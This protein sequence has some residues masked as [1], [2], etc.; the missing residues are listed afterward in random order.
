MDCRPVALLALLLVLAGCDA[1]EHPVAADSSFE[2]TVTGAQSITLTGR[3]G[4]AYQERGI[5]TLWLMLTNDDPSSGGLSF[6]RSYDLTLRPGT[7][8]VGPGEALA[9][10]FH[11]YLTLPT[12]PDS[13]TTYWAFDGTLTVDTIT[14]GIAQGS[15][16][17]QAGPGPGIADPVAVAE[18][19][20]KAIVNERD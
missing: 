11:A 19:T 1:A 5:P 15:F 10:G 13:V 4:T 16:S 18:G 12:A 2:A 8:N 6:S 9:G 14:D 3:T 7:Y 17:V 20:F